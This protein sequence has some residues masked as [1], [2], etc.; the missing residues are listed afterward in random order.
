MYQVIVDTSFIISAVKYKIDIKMCLIPIIDG[1]FEVIV[2]SPVISELKYIAENKGK[3]GRDA[4]IGL[5]VLE[6]LKPIIESTESNRADDAVAEMAG[7]MEDAIIATNDTELKNS[8]KRKGR[9]VFSVKGA[10]FIG[11]A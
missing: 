10:A 11:Q 7:I 1:P 6:R 9:K 3:R 2:P 8:L 5:K 4:T